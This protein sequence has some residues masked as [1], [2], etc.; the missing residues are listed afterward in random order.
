MEGRGREG[1]EKGDERDGRGGMGADEKE[2]WVGEGTVGEGTGRELIRRMRGSWN[3]K[4]EGSGVGMGVGRGGGRREETGVEEETGRTL[5]EE[6]RH[7][8]RVREGRVRER[9]MGLEGAGWVLTIK[10]EGKE[11]VHVGREKEGIRKRGRNER[12]G[13]GRDKKKWGSGGRGNRRDV[14]GE[15]GYGK[16]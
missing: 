5:G 12:D 4:R 10:R 14:G 6:T 13:T 15:G 8:W 11:K 7:K 3:R 1:L 2:G 16:K 9:G